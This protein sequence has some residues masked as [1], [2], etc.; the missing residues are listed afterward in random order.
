[1]LE[2]LFRPH[3][4]CS[5]YNFRFIGMLYMK[6]MLPSRIIVDY[7]NWSLGKKSDEYVVNI[8]YFLIVVG[9]KLEQV[10]LF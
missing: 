7:I 3:K 6:N 2:F 10:I 9:K 4:M 8:C 1:M 5:L